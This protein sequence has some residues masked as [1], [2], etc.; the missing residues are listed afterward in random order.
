MSAISGE[1]PPNV[2]IL[3]V[4]S[5][6]KAWN[7]GKLLF[8]LAHMYAV[9]EHATLSQPATFSLATVFAK[10]GLKVVSAVE[11]TL[12]GNQPKASWEAKKKKWPTDNGYKNT[13][14]DVA[15]L[16]PVVLE[17]TDADMLVTIRA[18]EVKTYLVAVV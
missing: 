15:Q 13:D 11:T 12:T 17:E 3:T 5:N 7:G 8:R 6:Y 9:G 4:S 2:K 14:L 10:A 16:Q 18:M 1:L